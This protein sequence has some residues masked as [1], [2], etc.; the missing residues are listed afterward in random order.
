MIAART[1]AATTWNNS[2]VPAVCS[3]P[4]LVDR[5]VPVPV[6]AVPVIVARA[7]VADGVPRRAA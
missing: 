1:P 4:I 7:V 5:A 6:L 2:G 3:V